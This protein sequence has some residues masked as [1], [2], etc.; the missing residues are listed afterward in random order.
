MT[1]Q[2]DFWRP[3]RLGYS[4]AGQP[5][6]RPPSGDRPCDDQFGYLPKGAE[7]G[8]GAIGWPPYTTAPLSSW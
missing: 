8:A 6:G 7:T 1:A 5:E 2:Y 4:G 3:P